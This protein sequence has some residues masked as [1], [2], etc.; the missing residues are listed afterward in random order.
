MQRLYHYSTAKYPAIKSREA[1]GVITSKEDLRYQK[2]RIKQTHFPDIYD[3]SISLFIDPI[4]RDI[5][6]YYGHRHTFWKTGEAIY[7]H[8]ICLDVGV[9]VNDANR[10]IKFVVVETPYV[11]E[12]METCEFNTK[13]ERINFFDRAFKLMLVHHDVGEGWPQLEK[14]I[15]RWAGKTGK[16]YSTLMQ[17]EHFEEEILPRYA[18]RI[19]HLI[20]WPADGTLPVSETKRIVLE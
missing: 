2:E 19:P 8:C 14:C 18:A 15:K 13:A 5:A 10:L 7:E 9:D 16:N 3:R 6:K 20:V 1:Q 4:P 11:F 17:D 12:L